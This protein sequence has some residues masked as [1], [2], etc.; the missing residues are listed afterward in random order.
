MVIGLL[1]MGTY[2]FVP[3]T[4][5]GFESI[6]TSYQPSNGNCQVFGLENKIRKQCP[7][8]ENRISWENVQKS[9]SSDEQHE[10]KGK[11]YITHLQRHD[12][13]HKRDSM[14]AAWEM[15]NSGLLRGHHLSLLK[16]SI[17][18]DVWHSVQT[19][20]WLNTKM[21]LFVLG[22]SVSEKELFM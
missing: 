13:T 17:V 16:F 19:F 8:L 6:L 18:F 22:H 1:R 21:S 10:Q 14:T 15:M 7:S 11:K 3:N 4:T 9:L 12:R 2:G 20:I 5:Y